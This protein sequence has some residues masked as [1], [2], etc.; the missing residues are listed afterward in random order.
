MRA[1]GVR[2]VWTVPE[3]YDIKRM[4]EALKEALATPESG[5]KVIV[6]R[7]ECVLIRQRREGPV[8]AARLKG[9][10]RVVRQR[11]GTD[12]DICSGD[13]TCIRLSGCPSLTIAPNPDPLNPEPVTAV[14]GDC[15]G[16]G[17][18]GEIAHAAILCPSY[19][20]ATIIHNPSIRD[21]FGAWLRSRIISYFQRRLDRPAASLGGAGG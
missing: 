15:N 11:Y 12:P 14:S 2:W 16:C 19:F 1:L 8:A 18:C 10:Q 4:R 17:L 7:S 3:T 6:A 21:R 13:H 20:R 9:G 5:P